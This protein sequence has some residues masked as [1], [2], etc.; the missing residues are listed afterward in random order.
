MRKGT[1]TMIIVSGPAMRRWTVQVSEDHATFSG[2]P[3]VE[4]H[5]AAQAL[6]RVWAGRGLGLANTDLQGFAAALG[7]V[8]K[9]HLYQSARHRHGTHAGRG[10]AEV[11]SVPR[12]DD[13]DGFV[14]FSG[15]C[16]EGNG[17]VGYRPAATFTIW[18]PDVRGLRIRPAAY[19]VSD[20]GLQPRPK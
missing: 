10:S 4:D 9:T 1:V 14:Y 19:L 13:D 15:P 20:S 17:Q 7:E 16:G 12:R 8:M 6:P 11:W 18:L 2:A 3:G 5:I